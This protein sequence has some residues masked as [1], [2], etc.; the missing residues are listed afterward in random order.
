MLAKKMLKNLNP[1]RPSLFP[2]GRRR[3]GGGSS[4]VITTRKKTQPTSW[5]TPT[6]ETIKFCFHPPATDQMEMVRAGTGMIL[7]EGR[8][9]G[10]RDEV[11]ESEGEKRSADLEEQRH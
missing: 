5:P 7:S 4:L 8:A 1:R 10:G 9:L 2:F 6:L 11:T 3:N